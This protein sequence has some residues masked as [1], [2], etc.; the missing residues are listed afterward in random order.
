LGGSGASFEQ[1]RRTYMSTAGDLAARGKGRA[2]ASRVGEQEAYWAPAADLLSEA[3]LL[4]FV[5]TEQLPSARRYLGRHADRIYLLTAAGADAA[6]LADDDSA[7]TTLVVDKALAKHPTFRAF[8]LELERFP[9]VLPVI[10]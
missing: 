6:A 1:C 8:V 9:L 2:V 7:F 5:E 4:G 3:M 10:D